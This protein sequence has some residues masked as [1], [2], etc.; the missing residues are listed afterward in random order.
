MLGQIK[1][2]GIVIKYCDYSEVQAN[3]MLNFQHMYLNQIQV[4]YI[5]N[6]PQ[7]FLQGF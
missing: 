4:H 7:V 5:A 3:F 1:I 2:A 6:M